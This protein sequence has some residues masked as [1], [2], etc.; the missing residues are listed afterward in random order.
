MHTQVVI[1]LRE[2]MEARLKQ[3]NRRKTQRRL[4]WTSWNSNHNVGWTDTIKFTFVGWVLWPKESKQTIGWT[5]SICSGSSDALGLAIV[6]VRATPLQHRTIRCLDQ[7]SIWRLHL[8][9]TETRQNICFS[10]GWTDA[11]KSTQ[12][13]IRLMCLNHTVLS[14]VGALQYRMIRR[15]VGV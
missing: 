5:D 9:H 1:K 2:F 15:G 10:T 8:K 11:W 12:R 4:N 6:R 3:K 7:R 14:R 13:F